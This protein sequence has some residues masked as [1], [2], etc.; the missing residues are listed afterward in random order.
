MTQVI[1]EFC[2]QS[3]CYNNDTF[4]DSMDVH[5]IIESEAEAANNNKGGYR[6][7]NCE[8]D[9]CQECLDGLNSHYPKDKPFLIKGDNK[10]G[11]LV[12]NP[13]YKAVASDT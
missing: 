10:Y 9:I 7:T 13:I 2:D 8:K 4:E 6:I 1:V 11:D 5:M 3:D 12:V